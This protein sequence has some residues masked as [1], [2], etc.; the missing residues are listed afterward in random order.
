MFMFWPNMDRSIISKL[1]LCMK[2]TITQLQLKKINGHL[3]NEL[4]RSN[5]FLEIMKF[6]LKKYATQKMMPLNIPSMTNHK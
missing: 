6:E 4:K 2:F 3:E 5:I 1:D